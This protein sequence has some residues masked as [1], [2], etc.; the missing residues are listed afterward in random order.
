MIIRNSIR[1]L[2]RMKGKTFLFILLLLLASGLCSMGVGFWKINSRNMEKYEDSFMTI[3]TVEQKASAMQEI[4]LWDAETKSYHIYSRNVYDTYVPESVLD[5]EGAD[6]MKACI[7]R[8]A[9][10][11]IPNLR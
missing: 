4:E 6:Y 8:S 1:Q 3:G 2:W 10:T 5:F 9:A 11:M 7:L